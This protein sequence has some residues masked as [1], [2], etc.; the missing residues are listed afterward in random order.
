MPSACNFAI[1]FAIARREL[2]ARKIS[3]NIWI[4]QISLIFCGIFGDFREKRC[5]FGGKR[6]FGGGKGEEKE[7]LVRNGKTLSRKVS[8]ARKNMAVDCYFLSVSKKIL[9]KFRTPIFPKRP[10]HLAHSQLHFKTQ[11]NP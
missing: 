3:K 1:V 7:E 5:D 2:P 9:Q 4:T 6:R 10:N 11:K 8:R